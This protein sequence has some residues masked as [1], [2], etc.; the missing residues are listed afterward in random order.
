MLGMLFGDSDGRTKTRA[1]RM[2]SS[3]SRVFRSGVATGRAKRDFTAD[4][5]GTSA[6]IVVESRAVA[7]EPTAI[8]VQ[9]A[10]HPPHP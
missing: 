10:K 2:R 6:P 8:A 5:R 7:V 1:H 9:Q 3:A 4:F